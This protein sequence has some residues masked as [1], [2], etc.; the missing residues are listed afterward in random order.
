MMSA[1]QALHSKMQK[2]EGRNLRRQ[3][4]QRPKAVLVQL[5]VA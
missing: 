2:I 3:P 5:L 4:F 1:L